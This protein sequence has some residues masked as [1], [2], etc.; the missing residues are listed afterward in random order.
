MNVPNKDVKNSK[1]LEKKVLKWIK[2][3]GYPL[4]LSVANAFMNY[5]FEIS[6]SDYY[7]D[8]ETQQIREIDITAFKYKSH[9]RLFSQV[10]CCIEC[11]SSRDKPWVIF[12][13]Q[14]QPHQII[15]PLNL[16]CS[17]AIA[18]FFFQKREELP[19]HFLSPNRFIKILPFTHQGHLGHSMIQ[20]MRKNNSKDIAY[21]ALKSAVKASIARVNMFD[22]APEKGKIWPFCIAIPVIVLD[23][24]LFECYSN[25]LD[26]ELSI[27]KVDSG[28]LYWKGEVSFGRNCFV[29]IITKEALDESISY[30]QSTADTMIEFITSNQDKILQ[31]ATQIDNQN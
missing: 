12:V 7:K 20:A 30:L 1:D 13:S 9:E 23:G 27:K 8:Y 10:S 22:K 18:A 16:I 15:Q 19:L 21:E 5:N 28:I 2:E 24:V 11:K 31:I 14:S 4:E 17:E 3:E 6:V 25:G 26:E 29:Y